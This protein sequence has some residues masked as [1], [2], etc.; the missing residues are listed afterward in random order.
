VPQIVLLR[1]NQT[2]INGDELRLSGRG[3]Y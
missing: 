3:T 2:G 1:E